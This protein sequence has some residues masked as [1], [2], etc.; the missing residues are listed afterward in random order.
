MKR[1]DSAQQLAKDYEKQLEET[2]FIV[3]EHCNG[4]GITPVFQEDNEMVELFGG[5][6]AFVCRFCYGKKQI[7]WL[8]Y[9]MGDIAQEMEDRKS[10]VNFDIYNYVHSYLDSLIRRTK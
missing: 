10:Q 7:D 9:M 6:D 5:A 1:S 2:G 4:T 8:E 3:C